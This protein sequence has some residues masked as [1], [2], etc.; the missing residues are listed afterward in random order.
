MTIVVSAVMADG[1][2]SDEEAA[3]IRSMCA[4]SPIFARNSSAQDDAIIDFALN[5]SEQ[6]GDSAIDQASGALKP[7]LRETAFAFA[8]DMVLADGIVSNREEQF[9]T[10]LAS[11]L[12]LPDSFVHGVVLTTI[13][14]N[15]SL[16]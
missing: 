8:C 7:D 1:G 6:L 2:V 16:P 4:R 12:N 11:R 9:L 13:A 15:R 3:R 5:V 10:K 14:R